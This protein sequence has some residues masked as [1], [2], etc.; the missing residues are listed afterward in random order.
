MDVE[1]TGQAEGLRQRLSQ[2]FSLEEKCDCVPGALPQ[3]MLSQPFGL[4]K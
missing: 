4:K 2:A 3:A 1:M